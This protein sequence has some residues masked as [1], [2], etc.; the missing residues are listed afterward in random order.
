ARF[1]GHVIE[2]YRTGVS[3]Q[4][5]SAA[6]RPAKAR[7]RPVAGA[8]GVGIISG[9][10]TLAPRRGN[11]SGAR[12]VWQASRAKRKTTCKDGT[13]RGGWRDERFL[14]KEK[15]ASGRLWHRTAPEDLGLTF[16]RHSMDFLIWITAAR[17]GDKQPSWQPSHDQLTHGDLLLLFF[18]HEG[19]R[20][21]V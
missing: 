5:T 18:A 11:L 4:E 1:A 3:G 8:R 16:S 17:P 9:G 7:P 13:Q 2:M 14:R 12:R 20:D 15:P 10:G 21:T 6:A 19:L